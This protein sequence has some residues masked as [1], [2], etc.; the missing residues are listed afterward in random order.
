MLGLPGSSYLYQGEELGLHEVV[1]I[2]PEQRQ[3]PRFINTDGED[4]GRDGCRVPLPW[5]AE[6]SSFGFGDDGAHLP[7]PAWF[8]DFA[9]DVQQR[10]PGTTLSMYQKALAIRKSLQADEELE[11]VDAGRDDVLAFRRPN[12][13]TVV[14]NFGSEPY[15]FQSDDVALVSGPIFQMDGVVTVPGE[16]TVWL[17][18][19]A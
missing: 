18:P 17:E 19:T 12:G 3:D 1:E 7:Q 15:G 8:A 13:W 4:V 11:W 5:T 9:V 6:G 10:V 16:T 14:T 2:P